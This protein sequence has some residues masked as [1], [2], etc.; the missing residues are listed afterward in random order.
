[1][2]QLPAN[3]FVLW[4]DVKSYYASIDHIG[5]RSILNLLGQYLRRTAERGGCFHDHE[6]GISLGCPLR[7]CECIVEA[8]RQSERLPDVDRRVKPGDDEM[9]ICFI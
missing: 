2:A 1:M 9:C 3:G 6:R 8:G 4:T 5:D 7:A